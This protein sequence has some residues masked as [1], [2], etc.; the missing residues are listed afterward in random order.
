MIFL[1]IEINLMKNYLY[2]IKKSIILAD[3][4]YMIYVR[5]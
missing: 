3:T 1:F 2:R 5:Q 4:K